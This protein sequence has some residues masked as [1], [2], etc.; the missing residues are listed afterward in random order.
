MK[1]YQ[2][3]GLSIATEIPLPA[4]PSHSPPDLTVIWGDE[5]PVGNSKPEGAPLSEFILPSGGY[6]AATT[7]LGHI[8]RFFGSFE[9]R[10]S[11]DLRSI[12]VVRDPSAD[13][14]IAEV[15]LAS[16][17]LAIYL[18][19]NDITTLHASAVAMGERAVALVGGSGG[20]KSTIAAL[21]CSE[22]ALLV[23]DDLLR[24]EDSTLQC[25]LGSDQVRIRPDA[26]E[27]L[28]SS[29]PGE[30][31]ADGRISFGFEVPKER[32]VLTAIV[33][34]VLSREASRILL[35]PLRGAE[36][37]LEV[38]RFPRVVGWHSSQ[39]L[40]RQFRYLAELARKVPVY[41]AVVPWNTKDSPT[42]G[43]H[44]L[45]TFEATGLR[46]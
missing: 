42:S 2:I 26:A 1:T 36:A 16:S 34:P 15:L 28:F 19:L 33:S 45:E 40:G 5:E 20:G 30:R 31:T 35:E 37:L 25:H 9:F 27:R 44:L 23:T 6:A 24:I 22:G 8:F 32:P 12:E 17:V 14:A 29:L 38:I 43:E 39:V 18:G 13:R 4:A 11:L 3:Y 41:R 46:K 21:L 10:I 7:D